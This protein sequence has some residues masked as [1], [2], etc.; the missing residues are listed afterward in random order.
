MPLKFP[1]RRNFYDTL[2]QGLLEIHPKAGIELLHWLCHAD[3]KMTLFRRLR[4]HHGHAVLHKTTNPTSLL[5][6]EQPTVAYC[7]TQSGW[8]E[9]IVMWV[10]TDRH[11]FS[12]PLQFINPDATP[13]AFFKSFNHI[14]ND[15]LEEVTRP[16]AGATMPEVPAKIPMPSEV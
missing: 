12:D 9:D 13:L 11:L 16:E 4:D 2:E 14:L 1:Y 6:D 5:Y 7:L 10:E 3:T 8:K 15:I